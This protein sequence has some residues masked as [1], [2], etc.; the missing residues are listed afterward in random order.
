MVRSPDPLFSK[1]TPADFNERVLPDITTKLRETPFTTH[2]VW[3][4]VNSSKPE[5]AVNSS[6]EVTAPTFSLKPKGQFFHQGSDVSIDLPHGI[7]EAERTDSILS[8]VYAKTIYDVDALRGFAYSP[9]QGFLPHAAFE[10]AKSYVQSGD[11]EIS[12][13]L[14]ERFGALDA[15]SKLIAQRLVDSLKPDSRWSASQMVEQAGLEP[16]TANL[17]AATNFHVF[18]LPEEYQPLGIQVVGQAAEAYCHAT[19][20]EITGEIFRSGSSKVGS[21][22]GYRGSTPYP[23]YD[24]IFISKACRGF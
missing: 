23:T 16:T 4:F 9:T 15:R 14:T 18:H 20:T 17:A 3:R 5:I 6:T 24:G 2:P 7:T 8:A 12:R 11:S 22:F 19:T 21:R 1:L 13:A 10:G